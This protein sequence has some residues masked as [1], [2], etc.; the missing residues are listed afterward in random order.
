MSA[1]GGV[2][3]TLGRME[4][5]SSCQS[6][7]VETGSR[8]KEGCLVFVDG[9]LVAVLVRL[10]DDHAEAGLSGSWFVEAGFGPCDGLGGNHPTFASTDDARAWAR[11]RVRRRGRWPD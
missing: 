4:P 9:R 1:A 10:G 2:A 5:P 8:D 11:G 6:V 7:K 3:A